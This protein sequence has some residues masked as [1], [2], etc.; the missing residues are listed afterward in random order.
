MEEVTHVA[1]IRNED[2]SIK[3]YRIQNK[4]GKLRDVEPETLYSVMVDNKLKVHNIKI[5]DIMEQI[6][7]K[8]KSSLDKYKAYESFESK[9][10]LVGRLF[11]FKVMGTKNNPLIALKKCYGSQHSSVIDIPDFVDGILPNKEVYNASSIFNDCKYFDKVK[12]RGNVTGRLIGLFKGMDIDK[13]DLSEFDVSNITNMDSMFYGCKIKSLEFGEYFNTSKVTNM[14]GM[15]YNS[16]IPYLSLSFDTT[17]LNKAEGMFERSQCIEIMLGDR[18]NTHNVTNMKTMFFNCEAEKINLGN[19]FDTTNVFDMYCM[20]CNARPLSLNLGDKFDTH[21]VGN[22]RSMF[23][24]IN[25]DTIK[26]GSKF[27]LDS[28]HDIADI[29]EYAKVNSIYINSDLDKKSKD[30]LHKNTSLPIIELHRG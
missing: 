14:S 23:K 8:Y 30:M 7:I 27:N 5:Y 16:K 22:M 21:N 19:N 13:L 18:F 28:I 2:N 17:N 24:Y 15:F 12:M 1:T 4:Y 25:T 3:Y 9:Q 20:F 29:F 11:D 26:L 6:N 10:R